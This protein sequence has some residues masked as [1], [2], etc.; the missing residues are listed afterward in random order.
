VIIG[1]KLDNK[2]NNIIQLNFY[3][4][5]GLKTMNLTALIFDN[6]VLAV[7]WNGNKVDMPCVD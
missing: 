6:P 7:I 5:R 1:K 2:H 4:Y 3:V